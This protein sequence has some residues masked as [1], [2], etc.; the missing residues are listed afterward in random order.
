MNHVPFARAP[1]NRGQNNDGT[2][3]FNCNGTMEQM[4]RLDF[5]ELSARYLGQTLTARQ[6]HLLAGLIDQ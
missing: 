4:Q 5:L 2:P 1:E 3:L 6:L